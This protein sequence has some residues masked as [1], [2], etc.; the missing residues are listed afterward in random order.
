MH[1]SQWSRLHVYI[2]LGQI[3]ASVFIETVVFLF[4]RYYLISSRLSTDMDTPERGILRNVGKNEHRDEEANLGAAKE[5][6][7][8]QS[9]NTSSQDGKTGRR[10]HPS[11]KPQVTQQEHTI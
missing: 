7:D 3:V 11:H 8:V 4:F 9:G 6:D 1:A 5:Q 2:P 10:L